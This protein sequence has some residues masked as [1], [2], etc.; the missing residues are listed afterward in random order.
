MVSAVSRWVCAASRGTRTDSPSGTFAVSR[1]VSAWVISLVP[2]GTLT[3]AIV[4][5]SRWSIA[6]N[7]VTLS[8]SSVHAP[9]S[10]VAVS[11]LVL[12][13]LRW[14][15]VRHTAPVTLS[16][17]I[18]PRGGVTRV[19]SGAAVPCCLMCDHKQRRHGR[20][21]QHRRRVRVLGEGGCAGQGGAGAGDGAAA[22][23]GGGAGLR[24]GAGAGGEGELLV[25]GGGGRARAGLAA[26]RPG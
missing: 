7:S 1:R 8:F 22:Q 11:R 21:G 25:A 6:E 26:V 20:T 12:A 16:D 15:L 19:K 5:A 24:P 3:C 13:M 9:R 10:T 17:W 23:R 2:S 4:M 14:G 18:Q